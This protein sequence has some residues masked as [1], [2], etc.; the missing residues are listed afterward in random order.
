MKFGLGVAFAVAAAV[1]VSACTL[2]TSAHRFDPVSCTPDVADIG[3]V[4]WSKAQTVDVRVRQSEVDPMI[5]N[6]RRNSPYVL[7]IQ[8]DD[9][10][11]RTLRAHDF[12][13]SVALVETAV[14]DEVI[15]S[16]CYDSLRVGPG[17]TAEVRFI[18]GMDG[19]YNFQ[20]GAL[21]WVVTLPDAGSIII[22]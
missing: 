20:V 21:P 2:E 13:R 15:A 18:T 4:D 8:N 12:F 3:T 5:I 9:P 14:G 1:T 22:N 17:V 10:G 7:R 19:R 6:L 16:N 11:T